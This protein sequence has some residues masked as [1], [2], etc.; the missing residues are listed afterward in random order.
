MPFEPSAER[1]QQHRN[2]RHASACSGT[3]FGSRGRHPRALAALDKLHRLTNT[4]YVPKFPFGMVHLG[5]GDFDKSIDFIEDEYENRGWFLSLLH[6]APHL[7]PLRGN[8]RFDALVRRLEFP[9]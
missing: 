5:L 7:D 9:G 2:S 3:R 1:H 8:S 6:I 4:G